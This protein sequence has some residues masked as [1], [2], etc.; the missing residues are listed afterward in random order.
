MNNPYDVIGEFEKMV[1]DY[2]GAPFGIAVDSCTNALFLSFLYMRRFCGYEEDYVILPKYTY[3]GVAQS[4][5]NAGLH[6]QFT[7]ETWSGR[8]E[9]LPFRIWDSA[10]YFRRGMYIE[11]TLYCLSFQFTKHI[12]I[13][14]GGM[15]LTDSIQAKTMLEAMSFDGRVRR[16]EIN[17]E[18]II[19]PGWHMMMTPTQALRGIELMQNVKDEYPDIPEDYP[20]LQEI[21]G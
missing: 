3:V 15:I 20:D 4:A 11:N 1:A 10:R 2:A 13:E 9:I 18:N 17:K 12:P 16:K 7:N 6:I 14:R 19:T 5:W 21:F 8:Y